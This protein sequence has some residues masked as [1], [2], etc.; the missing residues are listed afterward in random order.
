MAIKYHHTKPNQY[1]AK[2]NQIKSSQIKIRSD[3]IRNVFSAVVLLQSRASVATIHDDV[4]AAKKLEHPEGEAAGKP[5][6]G[7]QLL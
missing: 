5:G 2:P 3:E 1:Q 4:M 6:C 7:A